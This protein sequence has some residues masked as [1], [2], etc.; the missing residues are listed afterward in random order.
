VAPF[1]GN[2]YDRWMHKFTG[3]RIGHAL[4]VSALGTGFLAGTYCAAQTPEQTQQWE[5]QRAQTQLQEKAKAER[6]QREREARRAD[7]MAW[8]RTLNPMPAGGWEFRAVAN[9]GSWAVFST[10]HQL[11]RSHKLVTVWLRQEYAEPQTGNN[12]RYLSLVQKIQ[13]DCE[14]ERDRPLLVVYYSENNIQGGEQTEESDEKQA[15][16]SAIVP[17]TRDEFNYAWACN[18]AQTRAH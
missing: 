4:V 5:V 18:A 11:K 12:G 17:G 15:P 9:D 7:P 3:R 13:Y 6:L 10:T 1:T 2:G 8:V 16:W 14:K